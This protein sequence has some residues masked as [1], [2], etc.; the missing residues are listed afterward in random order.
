MTTRIFD[1]K[2]DEIRTV[3]LGTIKL[4]TFLFGCTEESLEANQKFVN[5]INNADEFWFNLTYDQKVLIAE[6]VKLGLYFDKPDIGID[7]LINKIS[8][9]IRSVKRGGEIL[10]NALVIAREHFEKE[11]KPVD[12]K[13]IYSH[14]FPTEP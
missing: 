2:I 13:S 5:A 4:L 9:S 8:S 3:G 12:I 11:E 14:L 1:Q 7:V 10:K 6:R